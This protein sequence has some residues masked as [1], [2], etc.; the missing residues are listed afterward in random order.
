MVSLV[1][2]KRR[3]YSS[4]TD[5]NAMYIALTFTLFISSAVDAEKDTYS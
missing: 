4:E 5:G 3:K 1:K 2:G